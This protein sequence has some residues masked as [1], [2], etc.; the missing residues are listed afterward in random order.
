M[1][2]V[3]RRIVQEL[4]A[5]L[6]DEWAFKEARGAA[7]GILFCWNSS[8]WR[9]V[10]RSVGRHSLSILLEDKQTGTKWGCSGVYGPHEDA[11]RATLW[12]ELSSIRAQWGVPVTFMGDFNVLRRAEERNRGGEVSP[13]M[14]QF[15]DW[16]EEEGLIDLPISNHAYTWS[17]MREEPSLA[18]LDRILV[19]DEWESTHPSCFVQGLPRAVS[20]HIPSC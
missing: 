6:L 7:G 3:D 4:G 15:S 1:E 11:E 18:R 9:V 19:D 2:V 5:G 17:N 13:A 8:Y 16:I 20:D 14:V 10:D 12:E